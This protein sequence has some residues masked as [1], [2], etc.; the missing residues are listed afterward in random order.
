VSP[1][2]TK[3]LSR[4]GPHV[5]S[6]LQGTSHRNSSWL[7][8]GLWADFALKPSPLTDSSSCVSRALS[9]FVITGAMMSISKTQFTL[10]GNLIQ[11]RGSSSQE[12][13]GQILLPAS[14]L[15]FSL[16]EAGYGA[17]H[18]FQGD[19]LPEASWTLSL[20]WDSPPPSQPPGSLGDRSCSKVPR[21]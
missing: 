13:P 15:V 5:C 10:L 17:W 18:L 6:W 2:V 20:P 9:D 21:P 8:F 11:F 12:L 19:C 7:L 1:S 4:A 16:R 3:E 14:G